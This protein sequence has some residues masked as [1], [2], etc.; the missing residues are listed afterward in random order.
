MVL[1]FMRVG[2]TC[3]V[4]LHDMYSRDMLAVARFQ[5]NTPNDRFKAMS[6]ILKTFFLYNQIIIVEVGHG[7]MKRHSSQRERETENKQLQTVTKH[8]RGSG[9]KSN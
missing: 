3:T 1:V 7:P 5:C 2:S 4:D 9:H 8:R 6:E